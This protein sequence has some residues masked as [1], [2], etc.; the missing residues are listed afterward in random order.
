[1]R[2]FFS[3]ND[4]KRLYSIKQCTTIHL[5]EIVFTMGSCSVAAVNY[6]LSLLIFFGFD[7]SG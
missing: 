4:L 2:F 1:M 3:L 7:L 6:K 5:A